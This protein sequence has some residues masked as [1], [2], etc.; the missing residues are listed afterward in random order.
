VIE[1]MF[2]FIDVFFYPS[3][4]PFELVVVDGCSGAWIELGFSYYLCFCCR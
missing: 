2:I 4:L 1:D 3:A